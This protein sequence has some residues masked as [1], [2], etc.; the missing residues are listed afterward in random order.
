MAITRT[1]WVKNADAALYAVFALWGVYILNYLILP[2]N[3]IAHGIRPRQVSS[4]HGILLCPFLHA[5]LGHIVANSGSL[6][7]LL[8]LSLSFS[9]RLTGVSVLLSVFLGG[10]I[11]WLLGD[12]GTN[13]IGASG[14]VFGLIG[15]LLSVGVFRREPRAILYGLAALVLYGGSLLTLVKSPPGTSWLAHASGFACGILV[16][17]LTRGQ[18][19]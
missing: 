11:V 4:I 1:S 12:P 7:V 17:W 3:F 13:H 18:V 6:F 10:A 5:N 2:V 19:R 16:A 8:T 9:R 15:F 14:I